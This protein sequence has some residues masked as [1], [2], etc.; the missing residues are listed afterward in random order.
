[1]RRLGWIVTI[2]TLAWAL[3]TK[4]NPTGQDPPA[5]DPSYPTLCIP[6]GAPDLDCVDVPASGFPVIGADPDG[7]DGNHDGIGCESR[8]RQ[9]HTEG[10]ETK[11]GE[12]CP[13]NQRGVGGWL[14]SAVTATFPHT[15]VSLQILPRSGVG[16]P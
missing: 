16:L 7:F 2:L 9:L 1:M 15:S 11:Q 3:Y 8:S 6:V 14:G 4:G 13:S 10:A 5:C 12:A